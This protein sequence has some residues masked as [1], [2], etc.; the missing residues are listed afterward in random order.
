M[1]REKKMY[2]L[3]QIFNFFN[4]SKLCLTERL[5]IDG[6]TISRDSFSIV[7]GSGSPPTPFSRLAI[8]APEWM[9]RVADHQKKEKIYR[10]SSL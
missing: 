10:C 1:L 5:D 3:M 9:H 6:A 7:C 8:I 4:I 2:R